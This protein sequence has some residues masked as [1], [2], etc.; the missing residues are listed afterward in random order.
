MVPGDVI[1]WVY[2]YDDDRKFVIPQEHL[3]SSLMNSYVPIGSN[4]VHILIAVNDEHISWLNSR[5]LFHAHTSDKR[6]WGKCCEN[7]NVVV[8]AR[9]NQRHETR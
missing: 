3:W 2:N 7:A 8:R 9:W 6:L 5:G 4:F 1:I